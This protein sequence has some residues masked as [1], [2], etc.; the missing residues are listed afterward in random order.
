MISY[1]HTLIGQ[2]SREGHSHPWGG[3]MRLAEVLHFCT[4]GF[5]TLICNGSA[6]HMGSSAE[7]RKYGMVGKRISKRTGGQG[8]FRVWEWVHVPHIFHQT[9][10]CSWSL[11]L[12]ISRLVLI[13]LFDHLSTR[14]RYQGSSFLFW[15]CKSSQESGLVMFLF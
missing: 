5:I 12:V 15:F 6:F 13:S 2:A 9:S 10:V 1:S 4:S 3:T 7:I 11:L 14:P 8:V